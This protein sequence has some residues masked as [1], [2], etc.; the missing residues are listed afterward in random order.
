MFKRF[1][2]KKKMPLNVDCEEAAVNYYLDQK[3]VS[4]QRCN[5]QM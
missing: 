5:Q 3:M 1:E 4:L 2:I